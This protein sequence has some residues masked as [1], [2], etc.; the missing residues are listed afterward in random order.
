MSETIKIKKDNLW[1]YAT[2]VLVALVIVLVAVMANKGISGNVVATNPTPSQGQ[3]L[4]AKVS[5]SVDD[6][7]FMGGENAKVVVIEFSDYECPFCKRHNEQTLPS[8]KSEYLDSEKVKYVFRDFTPTLSNP[9]YH[10]NAVKAAIA[11]ECVREVGGNSAYWEMHEA[12]FANQGSNSAENLKSLAQGLGYD[13]GSCLDSDKFKSEVE[14][15]FADG[16]RY[17][18]QG[19]PGFLIGSNGNYRTLSGACPY[20]AFKQAIDAELAGKEWHSPGN[21]QVTVQ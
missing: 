17:G 3:Q 19:T 9:S 5:A 21:C 14:K 15:D 18:I 16:Q 2:F 10:P 13:I 8:I 4:P 20:S 12:I 11:A 6:D 1:K 7:P